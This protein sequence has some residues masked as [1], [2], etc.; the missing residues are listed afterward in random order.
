MATTTL[1]QFVREFPRLRRRADA[2]EII[3]VKGR[4]GGYVFKSEGQAPHGLLGCCVHLA[5]RKPSKAGPV[6]SAG[7]WMAN[8]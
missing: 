7:A 8:R 2:G 6:E 5:S 1:R 3:R 4:R